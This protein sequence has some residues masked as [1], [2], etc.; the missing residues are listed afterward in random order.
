MEI[1][2]NGDKIKEFVS[3]NK[4][5]NHLYVLENILRSMLPIYASK[6]C[7]LF[8]VLTNSGNLSIVLEA[9]NAGNHALC[10]DAL[11]KLGAPPH[12]VQSRPTIDKAYSLFDPSSWV[13]DKVYNVQD[14]VIGSPGVIKNVIENK[15]GESFLDAEDY[16]DERNEYFMDQRNG[17]QQLHTRLSSFILVSSILNMM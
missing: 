5:N 12:N 4:G 3:K 8:A 10:S 7:E 17:A 9:V 6:K 11:A 15:I 16:V 1:A 2:M 13:R 14:S